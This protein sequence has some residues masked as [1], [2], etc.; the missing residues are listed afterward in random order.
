MLPQ[1]DL[2]KV[3]AE[4]CRRRLFKFVQE[5][6]SV[7]IPE[8]PVWNW[9]IETI[10]DEIQT[11]LLRIC[12]L[13]ERWEWFETER[14]KAPAKN[15]EP[16]L[17]DILLNVPPGTT[18]STILS[19]MA[20]AWL[21]T[22]DATLRIGTGS[23]SGD[24]SMGLA[25]K[26]RDIIQ[27]DKYR[28]YFPE[29]KI[30]DDNNNKGHYINT[31]GGE[32]YATSTG[33]T[34]VGIHFHLIIIDDPVNTKQ[35]NS[36]AQLEE[37]TDFINTTLSTRKVDKK[38]TLTIIVMQRLHEKDPAGDWIRKW[39]EEGFKLKWICLPAKIGGD[40][41]VYPP[42]L[43]DKYINGFLDPIRLDDE[44]L[45]AARIQLGSY[46]YAGQMDQNPTP[47]GGGIWQ[48]WFVPVA[49]KDMPSPEQMTGYGTDWDTAYT[50]N[51]QNAGS[52]GV[53]SG[54]IGNIMYID[55][56][57]CFHQEFPQLVNTVMKGFPFPH[58]VEA[59]ACFV[60]GTLVR[61]NQG[62][63]PIEQI[64]PGDLALSINEDTGVNEYREVIK[65]Y[66]FDSFQY[67]CI[68]ELNNGETIKCTTNHEIYFEGTWDTAGNIARRIMDARLGYGREVFNLDPRQ[69]INYGLERNETDKAN[70]TGLRRKWVLPNGLSYKRKNKNS[71]NTPLSSTGIYRK[72]AQQAYSKSQKFNSKRQSLGKFGMV[73][74]LRK[75]AAF[76]T[77]GFECR[78]Q[79]RSCTY[80]S[81]ERVESIQRYSYRRSGQGDTFKIQTSGIYQKNVSGRIRSELSHDSGCYTS[82]LEACEVKNVTFDSCTLKVYDIKVQ[83]NHNYC[84]TSKNILVHNS[85]K[86]LK[87]V[88]VTAG[89]P[90]EEVQVSGDKMVRAL[91]ATPIAER[92]QVYVRASI[93]DKIYN[94]KDQGI[95]RFPKG[96]KQDLAD[97]IAQAICRHLGKPPRQI[98]VGWKKR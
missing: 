6:W 91:T 80:K 31:A 79:K 82:W 37:A 56:F 83:N 14:Y 87:Q 71:K 2:S 42:K 85:G 10:C 63:I 29:V 86:S 35:V 20:P 40:G 59:K 76:S 93:L 98:I 9:H 57:A 23:Y 33:G 34:I 38:I 68:F 52:A 73:N 69:A 67:L 61:T 65:T 96:P 1:I 97:T 30:R 72:Y 7:L 41:D 17:H 94:D 43:A 28:L 25:M 3:K 12:R 24:L 77:T 54:R 53:V 74:N 95:L 16:K 11:D 21:W 49:D 75:S 66:V 13:P 51:K 32:R 62:L 36:E 81:C 19:V 89:Y 5:F 26:S 55:R 50:D 90:A 15:R 8:D 27:S 70:G 48:Q 60:A 84:I 22:V 4:L 92:K 18:K 88:L 47:K 78:L 45:D 46:G 64:E 58:Y 44:V 39:Q